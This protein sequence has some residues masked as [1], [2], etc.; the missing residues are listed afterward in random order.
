MPRKK[1]SP[2]RASDAFTERDTQQLIEDLRAEQACSRYLDDQPWVRVRPHFQGQAQALASTHTY[3][4]LVP[5]NGWGKTTCMAM[6]ADML[7][8]RVDP[9][10][11]D[12]LPNPDRPTVAIWVTQKYQ[13]FEM[14]RPDLEAIFTP[15]WK[16]QEQKHVYV[17]PNGSRL[18]VLSSDS[19]WT[20]IQGV[21]IDAVYFDEHPDRKLWVELLYR[22]RGKKRTRYMVAATMTQGLTWFVRDQIQPVEQWAI[23]H[24]YTTQQRL[25]FQDHPKIFLWDVGGIADNP[26]MTEEDFEHYE[27]ITAAGDKERR[28]R[29][30]GGYA[31]FTGQAV[32][33]QAGLDAMTLFEGESGA[34][35]F[36]PDEDDTLRERLIYAA[37]SGGGEPLGHRFAGVMDRRFWDWRPL[38]PLENG[39]ITIYEDPIEEEEGNYVI[40]ADF[41][42]G[43]VGKDYDA[44]V[45]GRKTREGRIVQV[46]EAHGH[47][48]DI[49]FAEVL[50]ALGVWYFEAFICGERQF[51]LPALRRLY[52]EMGY[53]FLYHQR[54]ENSRARRFSDLLGHHRHT[55]DTII[56]NARLAVKR[57]DVEIRS[58]ENLVEHQRFQFRPRRTTDALDDVNRSEDLKMGA[59][60]GEHDDLV[61]ATAYMIHAANER[62]HFE[63]P[64][65]KYRPGSFGDVFELDKVLAGD[66]RSP[67]IELLR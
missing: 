57:H 55:G 49:F 23:E 67:N 13:Q 29:L 43:L 51:G 6:D 2:A 17:W 63:K 56:A 12:L 41:A 22:R 25:M 9:F 5:G 54:A 27:S 10:K 38:M 34:L 28:V 21:Q 11:P 46:A 33:D 40:G 65:P 1:S 30:H 8:Q 58:E 16:W 64:R 59:P 53:V 19:D 14:M 61:M 42:A 37:A 18:F 24:G 60:E 45:V 4:I 50:Y 62:V 66:R 15:G 36:K 3:R 47:W 26:E 48:G 7:M 32:F 52:D 20:A 39:R 44:A 31:D 35:V